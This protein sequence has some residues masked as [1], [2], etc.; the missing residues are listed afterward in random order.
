MLLGQRRVIKVV[1]G[2]VSHTDA[3]H[4]APRAT[5]AWHGERYHLAEPQCL[6]AV[7]QDGPRSLGGVS[8]APVF[9]GE[10]PAYLDAWREVR[11]EAGDGQAN[12]SREGRDAGNLHRPQPEAVLVEVGLDT[13]C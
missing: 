10:A 6:E 8:S 7:R 11:R 3:L 9:H 2:V 1:G 5:V 4:E 12:E 13:R